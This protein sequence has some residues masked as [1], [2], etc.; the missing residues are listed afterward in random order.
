M[1][2]GVCEKTYVERKPLTLPSNVDGLTAIGDLWNCHDSTRVGYNLFGCSLTKKHLHADVVEDLRS[3]LIHVRSTTDKHKVLHVEGEVSVEFLSGL[4]KASGEAAFDSMDHTS[5][6][7]EELQYAYD[8]VTYVKKVLP[9]AKEVID[10]HVLEKIMKGKLTSNFLSPIADKL[11]RAGF[12][13]HSITL[14]LRI[15]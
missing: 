8:R 13:F 4:I 2:M 3:T 7:E 9:S 11:N 14:R 1:D 15:F 6:S 10:E 12:M 5:L